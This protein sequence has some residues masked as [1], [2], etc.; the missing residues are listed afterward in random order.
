MT[1]LTNI[2]QVISNIPSVEKVQQV[3]QHQAQ[4][5]QSRLA[6][7]SQKVAGRKGKKIEDPVPS[8]RIDLKVKDDQKRMK[9]DNEKREKKEEEKEESNDIKHI[10]ISA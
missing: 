6:S 1:R 2:Q 5:E 3:Q 10:D 9:K 4:A 8:D 7:Q